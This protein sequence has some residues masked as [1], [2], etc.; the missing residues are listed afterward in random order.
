[1][2]VRN[3]VHT[4]K[5]ATAGIVAAA[6]ACCENYNTTVEAESGNLCPAAG[7]WAT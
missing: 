4:G 3:L 6:M 1:M 2:I 7:D 5:D